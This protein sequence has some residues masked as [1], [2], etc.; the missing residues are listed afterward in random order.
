MHGHYTAEL[1]YPG[2]DWRPLSQPARCTGANLAQLA[3][4]GYVVLIVG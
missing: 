3:K 2:H 4:L 1:T